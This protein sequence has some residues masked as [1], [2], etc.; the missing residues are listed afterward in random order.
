[1]T[2]PLPSVNENEVWQDVESV[3]LPISGFSP[4]AIPVMEIPQQSTGILCEEQ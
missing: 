2:I 1:M 3:F 4:Q